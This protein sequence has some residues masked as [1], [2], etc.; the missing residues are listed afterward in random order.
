MVRG[1]ADAGCQQFERGDECFEQFARSDDILTPQDRARE[2]E[3]SSLQWINRF[4]FLHANDLARLEYQSQSQA[5]RLAQRLIR[6]L[7]D[8]SEVIKRRLPFAHNQWNAV[9]VLASRGADRLRCELGVRAVSGK[10]LELRGS[11]LHDRLANQAAIEFIA[12]GHEVV[13]LRELHQKASSRSKIP[14]FLVRHPPEHRPFPM[15]DPW[16]IDL[17]Y[18][19][20]DCFS[21]W[22]VE[23]ARKTGAPRRHQAVCISKAT[24]RSMKWDGIE[25][26]AAGVVYP[27]LG[28]VDHFVRATAALQEVAPMPAYV[29]FLEAFVNRTTFSV[30]EWR[31]STHWIVPNGFHRIVAALRGLGGEESLDEAMHS[32]R[33]VRTCLMIE[34]VSFSLSLSVHNEVARVEVVGGDDGLLVGTWE[35][36]LRGPVFADH[37][38]AAA[39]IKALRSRV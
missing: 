2:R 37:L 33:P 38:A 26:A 30:D 22:E 35:A 36:E 21:W 7:V 32:G 19:E 1:R 5:T 17:G 10:D 34:G 20:A 14:D 4:G 23:R 28:P 6:R 25:I 8:R 29:S 24:T 39:I 12:R 31:F 11:A 9:Y 13:T 3:L 16:A 27:A 15:P 18:H